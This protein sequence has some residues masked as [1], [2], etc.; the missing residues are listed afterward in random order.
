MSKMTGTPKAV[1][2]CAGGSTHNITG[3]G[4]FNRRDPTVSDLKQFRCIAELLQPYQ[5][6]Y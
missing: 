1:L 3:A 6:G 5:L 2:M 4:L